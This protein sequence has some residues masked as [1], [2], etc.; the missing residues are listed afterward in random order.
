M[1]ESSQNPIF[2][3]LRA[4]DMLALTFELV[5]LVLDKSQTPPRLIRS[6]PEQ[7]AFV[8]VHFPPQHIAEHVFNE[9][10]NGQPISLDD[11][12]IQSTLADTTRLAFRV[13]DTTQSIPF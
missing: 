10:P 4:D 2:S 12:P 3:F 1:S 5:N 13:R 6:Q 9:A 7:D 11:A 8:I